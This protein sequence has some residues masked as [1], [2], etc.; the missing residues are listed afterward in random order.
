MNSVAH[1][2]ATIFHL[3]N[4]LQC[5]EIGTAG[6]AA[7]VAALKYNRTLTGFP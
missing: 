5:N 3:P 1:D 6:V 4:S 2:F 7:I